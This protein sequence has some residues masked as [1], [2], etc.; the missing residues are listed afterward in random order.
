MD[1][2]SK[3]HRSW[4][5]SRIRSKH[6][7]PE[8]LVRSALHRLGYRFRL[9]QATLPGTPDIALSRHKIAVFV[10]GCYWHQHQGCRYAYV[11]KSRKAYWKA[12]FNATRDRDILAFAKLRSLGWVPLVVWECEARK[13]DQLPELL[14]RLLNAATGEQL[15][16][17][18]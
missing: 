16:D 15:G 9:H 17:G 7:E 13:A 5:M 14:T 8:K 6:S 12:K 11:P 18:L 1:R 4:N 10:N 2:I 3:A